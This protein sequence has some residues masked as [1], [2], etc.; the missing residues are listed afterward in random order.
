M[1]VAQVEGWVTAALLLALAAISTGCSDEHSDATEAYGSELPAGAIRVATFNTSMSRGSRGELAA[2]L[3]GGQDLQARA[4]AE[5]IQRVRPDVLLLNELDRDEQGRAARLFCDLYLA[6]SQNGQPPIEYG[7]LYVAD[8]NTGLD[9]GYDLDHDGELGG[10][11]DAQGFGEHLGQYAFVVLS[12]Y[13]MVRDQMRTFRSFLWQDMPGA[14]LPGDGQ[15]AWYDAEQLAVLRLSSKNH[16]DLPIDVAGKRLHLL[17]HHPT[18]PA[19]DGPEDRNGLRNEAEIRL[20]ADYLSPGEASY[21]YD[22]DGISGGLDEGASFVI[23]GDHNADPHDGAGR[24]GA[25][26]QLLTHPRV[27]T[28]LTPASAG[29]AA[30]ALEQGGVNA[31]HQGDP[32]HDTGDFGDHS[33][34]N[35]RLDYVLPSVDLEMLDAQVFWPEA[36]SKLAPLID[37]SDHRLVWVDLQVH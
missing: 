1:G 36:G 20:W 25:M 18:P 33:V 24:P 7:Y 22:D 4:T 21:L 8:S 29:A 35:L 27:N 17:A 23:V 15:G 32:A 30:A 31:Q 12:R 3:E 26:D 11:G 2:D 34:G 13:P 16:L 10:P 9:S 19:F 5:I 6:E 28:S 14:E 37:H